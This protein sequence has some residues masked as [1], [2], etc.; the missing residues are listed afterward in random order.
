MRNKICNRI[1]LTAVIFSI[2]GF[3]FG[4]ET[5]TIAIKAMK[6][7]MGRSMMEL[8]M[9]GYSDPFY[10]SYTLADINSVLVSASFGSLLYADTTFDRTWVIIN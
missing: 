9:D 7:E 4:A 2:S 3:I 8:H 10:I 5:D 6:D 1:F